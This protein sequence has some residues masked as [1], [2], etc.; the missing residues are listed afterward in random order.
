MESPFHASY[1]SLKM[2]GCRRNFSAFLQG[3][4]LG[5]IIPLS[6]GFKHLKE[7][8]PCCLSHTAAVA[9][10]SRQSFQ[11]LIL[12]LPRRPCREPLCCLRF[13][14]PVGISV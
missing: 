1:N 12:P 7:P 4:G 8:P 3:R 9:L 11:T 13:V 10:P 14:T 6:I 2:I 5:E